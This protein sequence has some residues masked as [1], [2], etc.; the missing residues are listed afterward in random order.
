MLCVRHRVGGATSRGNQREWLYSISMARPVKFSVDQILDGAAIAVRERG[1]EAS[2][3]DIAAA[4]GVP[5]GSIYHRFSSRREVFVRL[6]IRSIRRFQEGFIQAMGDDSPENAVIA[7][8][9]HIPTFCRDNPLDA[10][11]MTLFHQWELAQ[12]APESCVEDVLHINDGINAA[13]ARLIDRLCGSRDDRR[14]GLIVTATR[15]CPYG[16]VRPYLGREIPRWIDEAVVAS[17]TSISRL[18]AE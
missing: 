2:I 1:N 15:M 14:D 7:S 16:L 18:A 8:A 3:A 10:F 5:S 4:S 11:A 12:D 9:L 17:A 6:W 13:T